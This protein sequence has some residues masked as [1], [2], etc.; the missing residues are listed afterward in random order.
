ME[1]QDNKIQYKHVK[2]NNSLHFSPLFTACSRQRKK[3]VKKEYVTAKKE[4]ITI[5]MHE[6]LGV[7]EQDLFYSILSIALAED[8]GALMNPEIENDQEIIRKIDRLKF[9]KKEKEYLQIEVSLYE[10]LREMNKTTQG[11]N[12]KL[13]EKSLER[14]SLTAIKVENDKYVGMIH[15]L[16][17]YFDKKTKKQKYR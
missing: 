14:L 17:Y 1:M 7:E 15:L 5:F 9:C 4:R 6:E 3:G 10:L 13:L 16:D 12:Y 8:R 11:K 2:N